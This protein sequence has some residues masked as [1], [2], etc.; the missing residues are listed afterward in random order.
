MTIYGYARVS[1]VDQNEDRQ[2]I[3]LKKNGVRPENIF[4][5]RRSGKDFNRPGWRKLLKSLRQDDLLVVLSLDRLGRNYQETLDQWRK[6]VQQKKAHIRVLDMPVLD[7]TQA[8]Y[9]DLGRLISNLVLHLLSYI[10]ESERKSIRERQRQG[11]AAAKARGVQFGR[12]RKPVPTC[13]AELATA[14]LQK[15]LT[16]QEA[17]QRAGMTRSTFR[18]RLLEF[19]SQMISR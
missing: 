11:I 2:I 18:R 3:A 16:I 4:C 14:V 17:A 5:D 6:I 7:T 19:G 9:G 10:A 8:A 12:R 13:L 1:T 15:N